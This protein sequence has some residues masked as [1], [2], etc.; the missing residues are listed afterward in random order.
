MS[1]LNC[2]PDQALPLLLPHAYQSLQ[3]PPS[4]NLRGISTV[5]QVDVIRIHPDRFHLE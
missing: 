3:S 5:E 1:K 4:E 2:L